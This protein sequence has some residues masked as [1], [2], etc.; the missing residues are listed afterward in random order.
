M[1]MKVATLLFVA[2]LHCIIAAPSQQALIIG[3]SLVV[4]CVKMLLNSFCTGGCP[5]GSNPVNCFVNPCQ[6][7]SC[8][9][10]YGATCVADYCGGCNARWLLNGLEVTNQCQG[11]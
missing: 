1:S 5:D 7:A 10:V 8:P 4:S 6:F 3:M 2:L 11:I 9:D